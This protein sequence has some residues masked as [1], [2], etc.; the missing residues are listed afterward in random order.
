MRCW[1][2]LQD[3]TGAGITAA[4]AQSA[5]NAILDQAAALGAAVNKRVLSYDEAAAVQVLKTELL[6]GHVGTFIV[7]RAT[8]DGPNINHSGK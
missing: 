6:T 8:S 3:H 2:L 1:L 5:L 4:A 7:S